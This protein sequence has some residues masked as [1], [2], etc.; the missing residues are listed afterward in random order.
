MQSLHGFRIAV[1]S[2]H[3][4]AAMA[5]W[6][7]Y[8]RTSTAQVANI[9]SVFVQN[10]I[11]IFSILHRTIC[12]FLFLNP[13][14]MH[15]RCNVSGGDTIKVLRQIVIGVCVDSAFPA[16]LFKRFLAFFRLLADISD[17]RLAAY[18]FIH[19]PSSNKTS[20]SRPAPCQ[21][22]RGKPSIPVVG[23]PSWGQPV[24]GSRCGL[25][26]RHSHSWDGRPLLPRAHLTVAIV[27]PPVPCFDCSTFLPKT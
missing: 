12:F 7:W 5:V 25:S 11:T 26:F 10:R 3:L 22:N 9:T 20:L 19:C 13:M 6:F 24:R 17:C 1:T 16:K 21:Q 4:R 15:H 14:P 8:D 27:S 23:H 18:E 2:I